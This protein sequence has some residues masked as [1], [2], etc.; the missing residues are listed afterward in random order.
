LADQDLV[1]ADRL[2]RSI[3]NSEDA[4]SGWECQPT[5]TKERLPSLN[6]DWS[7]GVDLTAP[8]EMPGTE[9]LLASTENSDWPTS[10]TTPSFAEANLQEQVSA[11]EDA[12]PATDGDTP[13]Q[14]SELEGLANS[15]TRQAP[16][17]ESLPERTAEMPSS[18]RQSFNSD[19]AAL[20]AELAEK[21]Q[22]PSLREARPEIA[23]VQE[24]V[25]DEP[26]SDEQVVEAHAVEVPV[27]DEP[28]S[29]FL[30]LGVCAAGLGVM[31]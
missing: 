16:A 30:L 1:E 9:P 23:D 19:I 28:A 15:E 22:M 3:L 27:D 8:R 17:S 13:S 24:P 2:P 10:S 31:T 12:A 21:F 18:A 25:T 20:R 14:A 11:S 6:D 26:M 7:I 4:D 5:F 29:D